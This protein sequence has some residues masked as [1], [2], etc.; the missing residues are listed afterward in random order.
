[1]TAEV[2]VHQ[3]T[4]HPGQLAFIKSPAKRKIIRAGRRGGKTTG[5]AYYAVDNFLEGLRVLYAAPTQDQIERFWYEVKLSLEE[6]IDAKVFYKN[7]TKRIIELPGTEQR[8]RAKTAW[9]ADS[10]RGDYAD[11]LIFDEWQLMNEDAWEKVGAPMLLDNNGDAVFI[12]TPPSANSRSVTKATDPRHASKLFK[13]AKADTSGRWGAF[14]FSSHDNPHISEEALADIV[15]DMTDL[16]YRM[17]I[18]AEDIDYVPGALWDFEV[19]DSTRVT[20]YPDL[21]RVVIGVDPAASTGQ[22]GIVAAGSAMVGNKMHGYTIDDATARRGASPGEWAGQ[23]VAAYNR[24]KAD[25][26]VG[27]VN[28][29]GD[30][31][32]Q[33]IRSVPGGESVNFKTVRAS[34]G[35]QTRAEPISALWNPPKQIDMEPRAHMVGKFEQLEEELCGWVPGRGASPNRLDA[36][37]WAYT[38]LNITGFGPVLL[39]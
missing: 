33:T 38:E 6:P 24:L 2:V 27:E 17:E 22:T 34:R 19:L 28:N 26:M 5:I 20:E 36:M 23:A 13:R 35:K 18:L 30:M 29:G 39:W 10:L 15:K 3:R 31:V 37:V 11:L 12:Y 21:S 16:A 4:P 25:V 7:E 1:M 14:H 9:N 8:I 32:E